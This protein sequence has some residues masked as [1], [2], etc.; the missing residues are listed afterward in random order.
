VIVYPAIDLRQGRCVRLTQGMFDTAVEYDTDPIAVARRFADAGATVIHVVDLDGARSQSARQTELVL[1]IARSTTMAVQT[2][3]GLRSEDDVRRLL[4]GGVG[5]VV[6]GSIAVTDPDL[7]ATL[8][9][10]FGAD[11]VALAFDVRLVDGTPRVETSGWQGGAHRT[12]DDVLS[13]LPSSLIRHAL[14][15]DIGRDGMLSGP[16]VD[17]YRDV[18]RRYPQIGWIASGGVA[19]LSDFGMLDAAG[20]AGVIVGKALYERRFTLEEA[21]GC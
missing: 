17:L 6:L 8:L 1:A 11:R 18:C 7:T 2:G 21:L 12:L 20:V 16:N 9:S 19:S 4:E 5:R 13:A 14:C 3:G 15:T 10:T